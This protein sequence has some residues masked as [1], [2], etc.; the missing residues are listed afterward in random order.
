MPELPAVARLE[1]GQQV[2]LAAVVA[3]MAAAVERN[4]A[5]RLIAAAERSR[6][7]MRRIDRPLAADEA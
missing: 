2:Q 5:V 4:N 1:V 3:A 7:E 6:H